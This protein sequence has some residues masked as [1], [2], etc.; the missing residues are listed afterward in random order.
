PHKRHY[1]RLTFFT[2]AFLSY[3][4][5]KRSE[6]AQQLANQQ[7]QTI[8]K[9]EDLN[10][11]IIQHLQSGMIIADQAQQIQL[12]NQAASQLTHLTVPPNTLN[13]ISPQLANA[14]STWRQQG[15]P[16][17]VL[18]NF[19][20][21]P[22]VY[23]RFMSLSSGYE[24][25]YLII[26]EDMALYNQRVQQG[27][28]ASLGQLTASIAHEIRNP[29][30]AISHA[31]QLL[32]ENPLLSPED[33]RLTSIIQTHCQRV[34]RIIEDILQLS[35]RRDSRRE[36]ILL[37][38]WLSTYLQDFV[39]EQSLPEHTFL[40]IQIEQPLF[41]SI[42]PNHLKQILDNLCLNALTY[43]QPE[44]GPILLRSLIAQTYP[45]VEIIDN[46]PGIS[47]ETLKHLFEP[48][49]T[50]SRNGTGLGLYISRELAELN[51]AKLSYYLTEN[52]HSCF[53]LSL[54]DAEKNLIEL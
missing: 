7:Q 39:S 23:S 24:Q 3:V 32:S 49:F 40:L 26:L 41:V 50:T 43:G 12:L 31:G 37:Q 42:D 44:R 11:Y 15:W 27:K 51:Q 22:D 13:D 30:G 36:N 25:I 33:Y 52:Q 38:S 46:G 54:L 8:I 28:L 20:D 34:N 21:Y 9:L 4:L 14:F 53:R 5:A 18:L 47:A 6:E 17:S 48:F 16:E 29:L 10:Q 35:R 19:T 45:C 1:H 2:I